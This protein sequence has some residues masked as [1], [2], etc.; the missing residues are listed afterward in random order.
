MP[1]EAM[2]QIRSAVL[3]LDLAR[4]ATTV[5]ERLSLWRDA[6]SL[7]G[8][9]EVADAESFTGTFVSR[10]LGDL[11][12]MR[13]SASTFR[14]ARSRVM[15][16]RI[17]R[18]QV[19]VNLVRRGRF[20][21]RLSR[22]KVVVEPGAVL[23]SRLASPMNLDMENASWLGLFI[24]M[25]LF[26][27]H[28]PWSPSLDAMVFAPDTAQALLLGGLLSALDAMPETLP[29]AD[30]A[31]AVHASFA[32]L[33]ICLERAASSLQMAA[34]NADEDP[35]Q[36]IR[37]FIAEHLSDPDLGIALI[38]REF[39]ISRSRLYRIMG[40]NADIAAIVRRMRMRGAQ[41]DIA[42]AR[43]AHLPLAEIGRRWG[44]EDERNFRRAFARE[45]GYPPSELR[46]RIKGD[47]QLDVA[48]IGS[49]GADLERW[50]LGL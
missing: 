8:D 48:G 32:L 2:R 13:I 40:E 47:P 33:E 37:R 43:F 36:P 4:D 12:T 16:R 45:F 21:G 28:M 42:D 14:Y 5:A 50:L 29:A 30:T 34:E 10:G 18:D 25:S 7:A 39:S 24:P 31:R 35:A 38:C 44:L 1:S 23:L 9:V 3:D 26:E 19:V 27:K 22:R 41:Q 46:K 17:R 11:R 20:T 15:A 49:V 6:M